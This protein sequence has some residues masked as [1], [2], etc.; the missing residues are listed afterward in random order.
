MYWNIL[1]ILPYQRNFNFINGARSIGKTYGTQIY[2]LKTCIKNKLETVFLVRTQDEKKKGILEKAYSKVVNGNIT[3]KVEYTTEVI[4]VDG[5]VVVRCLALSEYTKIKRESFMYV[6]Y[7]IFDEYML[8]D[9]SGSRY[10]TGYNEPDLFLNIY[11]TIDRDTD[12][13]ICFL[14]G[15]N[16]QFYNPYHI[17]K[18]FNIPSIERGK[19]WK[20]ENVLFQRA[21][22]SD[23]LKKKKA[24]SLYSKM[25]NG[26]EYGRYANEGEYIGDNNSFIEKLADKCFYF[27]TLSYN[28]KM[29]GVYI[30]S[31]RG[32]CYISDKYQST[33]P[34]SFALSVKDHNE[35]TKL[36][37]KQSYR[38]K[39]I[40]NALKNGTIRYTDMVIKN[41]IEKG[42]KCLL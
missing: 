12:R 5:N 40:S 28:K 7:L 41:T 29:F 11:H 4:T 17:H 35:T 15:N 30:D 10:V 2:T 9:V 34:F 16:T 20:S 3:G 8:E 21:E 31:N 14:L 6:K 33:F 32:L 39:T 13:V 22:P 38:L 42:L 19:I 36:I 27:A 37:T 18:A 26:T 25:I 23:E 1:D 24:N